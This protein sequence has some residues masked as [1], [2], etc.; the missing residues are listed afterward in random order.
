MHP[1]FDDIDRGDLEAVKR[2]L[3]ADSTVLEKR[4]W[5]WRQ[6]PLPYAIW[7]EKRTIALWLIDNRG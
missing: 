2:R 7:I 6:T 5:G 4:E 3:L 1:V